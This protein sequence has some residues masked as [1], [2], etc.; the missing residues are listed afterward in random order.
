[1]KFTKHSFNTVPNHTEHGTRK[2]VDNDAKYISNQFHVIENYRILNALIILVFELR[3][4][5]TMHYCM[6]VF[7]LIIRFTEIIVEHLHYM[8]K[9]F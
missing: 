9:V 8:P 3:F 5:Q 7:V 2:N 1:M 4:S 6:S